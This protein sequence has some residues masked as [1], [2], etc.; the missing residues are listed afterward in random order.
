MQFSGG[1]IIVLACDQ[2]LLARGTAQVGLTEVRVGVMFP[3]WALETI[4][5]LYEQ[6]GVTATGH[7]SL[8]TTAVY[9]QPSAEELARAVEEDSDD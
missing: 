5:F 1:A 7:E 9:L 8:D 3:A 4:K 6:R 2:R